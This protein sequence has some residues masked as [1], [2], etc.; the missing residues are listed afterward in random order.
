M[1]L[2]NYFFFRLT[3]KFINKKKIK[4]REILQK[5][6]EKHRP[7]MKE[8]SNKTQ[9]ICLESNENLTNTVIGSSIELNEPKQPENDFQLLFQRVDDGIESGLAKFLNHRK[10]K[11][12]NLVDAVKDS[13][14][15]TVVARF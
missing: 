5:I 12:V 1:F 2:Q 8:E 10:N 7:R 13:F 4:N 6:M 14:N 11:L 9:L 3:I 15:S